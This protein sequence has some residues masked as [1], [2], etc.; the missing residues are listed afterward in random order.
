MKQN[1]TQEKVKKFSFVK[2]WQDKRLR[3]ILVSAGIILICALIYVVL[4]FTVLK[5]EE[6]KVLPTEGNH[7]EEMAN[8]RPFVID[9]IESDRIVSI[10][11]ENE[12]GGFR[13]YRGEDD[14]YYFQDAEYMFYDQ[15]TELTSEDS[16]SVTDVLGSL[17]MVDSLVSLARYMLA[18]EEVVG[19][20]KTNLS[21]YGLEN[22]GQ[23]AITLTYLDETDKE[24]SKTAFIGKPTVSGSGYYVMAE[25]R[26][27]LYIVADNY[28][29]KCI[30]TDVKAYFLPQVAPNASSTEYID[31]KELSIKK[32]GETFIALR[33]LT[34]EEYK[35]TGELFTHVFT[36][37]NGYYPSTDNLQAILETFVSF[38]GNEVVEYDIAK[39][40]ED[41]LQ[42]EEILNLFQHYSLMDAERR[43]N[44]EL[45]YKYDS[46]D[47]TLYISSKL[48][49][50][51]E[52]T[53]DE[54][55]YIYY[56]YSPDFDLIA[57]FDAS[58]LKWVEWDM[59]DLLDNHS[60]S[61]P[62]DNVSTM[63]FS[64]ENTN[65]KFSLQGEAQ[66]LK[67]TSSTGVKVD[68]DNFRQLY[69][70]VLFTTMDG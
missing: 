41:P 66:E 16:D 60:F 28:L 17:S 7:G 45:Y 3:A 39:R 19:Y 14:Q 52:Q 34:D 25:G 27:A 23:A 69:K 35:E 22:R 42:S 67:V 46:F 56:V 29:S 54:K 30:F 15:N 10:D 50:T 51:S 37:P 31:V 43:W 49:V 8:G 33:D 36:T 59:L 11:V 26:D 20:D 5:T 53:T 55:N 18:T 64:F 44:Y 61:V 58:D 12:F 32:K 6:E 57:E 9:P 2:M 21:A 65:V 4:L 40:L 68:T 24:V 63:E 13:Y 70:S 1:N 47:I 62:I 38:K 48:E